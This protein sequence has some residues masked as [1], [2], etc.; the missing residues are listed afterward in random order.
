MPTGGKVTDHAGQRGKRL[1][2]PAPQHQ[3]HAGKHA[4]QHQHGDAGQG[5]QRQGGVTRAAGAVGGL[6]QRGIAHGEE[7]LHRRHDHGGEF[8]GVDPVFAIA[9]GGR[10][11]FFKPGHGPFE[12]N[13]DRV[14]E[15]L[16]EPCRIADLVHA[17]FDPLA[18]EVNPALAAVHRGV[19]SRRQRTV[20]A[21]PERQDRG[22]AAG[23][24]AQILGGA[25]DIQQRRQRSVGGRHLIFETVQ[26]RFND[27][28]GLAHGRQEA[29][30]YRR[31]TP[32]HR[33]NQRAI[34]RGAN[35]CKLGRRLVEACD[36]RCAIAERADGGPGVRKRRL[37]RLHGLCNRI[38]LGGG[39]RPLLEQRRDIHRSVAGD[40][41]AHQQNR[42]EGFHG[43]D[44]LALAGDNA[45]LRH[46]HLRTEQ[47]S[48]P[49]HREH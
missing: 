44:R 34:G 20:R 8:F 19:F 27:R 22:A 42:A 43:L 3:G 38:E 39:S 10:H 45:I 17:G 11:L 35:I 4:E 25:G 2:H 18:I 1:D 29:F 40:L 30:D 9:A 16:R 49:R 7:T 14:L 23:S 41:L 32:A 31:I 37:R 33:R 15:R 6:R 46:Q 5:K 12:I 36:N 24:N 13:I 47:H 48:Q 21:D 26:E 28:D